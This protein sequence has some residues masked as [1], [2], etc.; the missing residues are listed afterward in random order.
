MQLSRQRGDARGGEAEEKNG[1][2]CAHIRQRAGGRWC[3]A[4]T[5]EGSNGECRGIFRASCGGGS[6]ADAQERAGGRRNQES[7]LG[8]QRAG[9]VGER[10]EKDDPTRFASAVGFGARR[11]AENQGC[12]PPSESSPDAGRWCRRCAVV[13]LR[14]SERE[15]SQAP[16][17]APPGVAAANSICLGAGG[18]AINGQAPTLRVSWHA[19]HIYPAGFPASFILVCAAS[20]AFWPPSEPPSPTVARRR[21]A[22]RACAGSGRG[23]T[24]TSRRAHRDRL[25]IPF[26]ACPEW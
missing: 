24:T 8:V 11:A 23:P 16:A 15:A 1:G 4:R 10:I 20:T 13:A 6:L 19:L 14:Q 12:G 7:L 25:N 17:C 2:G 21:A 3:T 26:F 18:P 5:E 9:A 22:W